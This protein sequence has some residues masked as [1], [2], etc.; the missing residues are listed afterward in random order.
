VLLRINRGLRFSLRRKDG[1]LKAAKLV[2][3]HRAEGVTEPVAFDIGEESDGTQRVVDLLP[4]FHD[5]ANAEKESV[6]FVDEL[7]RSLHSRLT[8]GL[9]EGYLGGR[10][11]NAR[12]QLLFTT[13]DATLLDPGLFRKDEVWLIDKNEK[14]ES[15]LSSLS[16]FKLR[17]DKR[18]MKDYLLGRF[19]GVPNMHRLPLRP[20][21]AMT[22]KGS[23]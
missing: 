14:G 3:Y 6:V 16:E 21:A 1:E 2:S 12:S 15:E 9:I 5:L 18:L 4:A 22:S 19:G 20:A 17:S 8:R 23:D 13:H 7:D 11:P 10:P